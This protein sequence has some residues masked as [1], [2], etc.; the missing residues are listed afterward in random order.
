MGPVASPPLSGPNLVPNNHYSYAQGHHGLARGH[1]MSAPLSQPSRSNA[2]VYL[3]IA[4]LIAA[5]GVLAYLVI[6]K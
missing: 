2:V 1:A 6:T 4:I 3:L 5:I